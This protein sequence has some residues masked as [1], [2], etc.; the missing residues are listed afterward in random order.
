VETNDYNVARQEFFPLKLDVFVDQVMYSCRYQKQL[1][2]FN[3]VT[4]LLTFDPKQ[5]YIF[6]T[7]LLLKFYNI[8]YFSLNCL[9]FSSHLLMWFVHACPYATCI[10]CDMSF[11]PHHMILLVHVQIPWF[12]FPKVTLSQQLRL[13]PYILRCLLCYFRSHFLKKLY[14]LVLLV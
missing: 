7:M 5:I 13:F 4:K 12:F 9:I 10:T 3:V 8:F 11:L 14:L 2:L 6:K 1:L